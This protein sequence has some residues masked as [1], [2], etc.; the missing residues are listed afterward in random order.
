MKS[1]KPTTTI[2]A[3]AAGVALSVSMSAKAYGGEAL[4]VAAVNMAQAALSKV[5]S[6]MGQGMMNKMMDSAKDM[7]KSTIKSGN[8]SASVL[9]A[10]NEVTQRVINE[11]A[12]R[13]QETMVRTT[14]TDNLMRTEAR[15]QETNPCAVSA[16]AG[17]LQTALSQSHSLVATAPDL[18]GLTGGGGGRSFSFGRGGGV[19]NSMATVLNASEGRAAAGRPAAEVTTALAAEGACGSFVTP[20]SPRGKACSDARLSVGNSNG[21]E[22]A[23]V[24]ATTLIAGPQRGGAPATMSFNLDA[25]SPEHAAVA[26][27]RRNLFSTFDLRDLSPAEASTDA[28]RRYLA[29]RDAYNARMSMAEYATNR[30]VAHIRADRATIPVLRELVKPDGDPA[31]TAAY[32]GR[33]KPDWQSRG[34]STDE[35]INLEVQRR[36]MNA[37]WL[38][39]TVSMAA[40]P[41]AAEQLR[42]SALTNVLLFQL[43]Q[44]TRLNN[45]MLG[46]Q[47]GKDVR[48]EAMPE[49]RAALAQASK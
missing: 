30:H 28:G 33:V 21:F 10:G 23:D 14:H 49:M 26:A 11:T 40:E 22:N 34:V 19:N 35:L 45:I 6:N 47:M 27:Y 18:A 32:L 48:Q 5:I 7:V 2:I 4:I 41:R 1:F 12:A 36:Y 3:F 16:P 24:R 43:Y 31:F 9:N 17:G 25:G 15:Y 42:V 29:M 13:I 39:R 44:E 46:A 20:G 37:D 38:N 8:D